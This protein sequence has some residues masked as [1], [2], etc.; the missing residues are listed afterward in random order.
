MKNSL[1][2]AFSLLSQVGIHMLVPIILCLFIGKWLDKKFGTNILFLIIFI[3][4][5]VLSS[6]RNLYVLV[7]K[8]YKPETQEEILKKIAEKEQKDDK[9]I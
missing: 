4:L 2:K 7:I 8:Q 5:G 3:V 6:F 9:N 1:A